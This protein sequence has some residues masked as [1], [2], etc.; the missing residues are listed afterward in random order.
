MKK[1][2]FL[3]A[4]VAFSISVQAQS[5]PQLLTTTSYGNSLDTVTNAGTKSTYSKTVKN[6]FYG[7]TVNA[8]VIVTKISGTVGGSISLQGSMDGTNWTNCETATTAT[9]ATNN[10][11]ISTTKRYY[12][13]RVSWTGTGT[14][15]ASFKTYLLF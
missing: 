11:F 14:M 4:I 10:Y 7:A 6:W 13:Y 15:S 5:A 12:Y 8:H 1:L 2:L 9:D 3:F